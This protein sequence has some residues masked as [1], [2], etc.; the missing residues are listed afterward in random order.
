MVADESSLTA[1]ELRTL[2]QVCGLSQQQLA[3]KIHVHRQTVIR[4]ESGKIEIPRKMALLIT[5]ILLLNH[6]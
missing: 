3:D 6:K 4:W 5:R 1:N 2:R